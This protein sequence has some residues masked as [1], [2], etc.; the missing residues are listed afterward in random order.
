LNFSIYSDISTLIMASASPNTSLASS[1]ANCVLPTPVGPRK[2]NDPIG[3]F[4]SFKPIL[5]LKIAFD[6]FSTASFCPITLSLKASDILASLS[7]SSWLIFCRGIPVI[8]ETTSATFSP[9][10][11]FFFSFSFCS[12]ALV[13]VS[14]P[15]LIFL[16]RSLY[17]AAPS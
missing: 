6:I 16:S 11:I 4:G 1:L 9:S 2:T 8:R 13:S 7:F 12:Q 10:T 14:I 5:F 3:R 17:L 15:A